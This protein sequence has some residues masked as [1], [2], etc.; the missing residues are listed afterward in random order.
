MIS[1]QKSKI[2]DMI[3]NMALQ[4]FRPGILLYYCSMNPSTKIRFFNLEILIKSGVFFQLKKIEMG[5]KN[6]E[7]VPLTLIASIASLRNG[8]CNKILKE[9]VRHKL[10]AYDNGKGNRIVI[11]ITV[12]RPTR[13]F[14]EAIDYLS[15]HGIPFD[16]SRIRLLG[17]ESALIARSRQ[18][19]RKSNRRWQGIRSV[20]HEFGCFGCFSFENPNLSQ[21]IYI[22]ANEEEEQFCMKLHR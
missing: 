14:M 2:H 11:I 20:Q 1:Y 9:L 15:S 5:M 13:V 21:D 6:H 17:L 3:L 12:L 4:E 7:V 18:L 19:G 8:G 22:A 10:V 16:L